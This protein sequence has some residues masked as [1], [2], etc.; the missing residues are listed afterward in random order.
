[1][2]TVILLR[3]ALLKKVD[4]FLFD[5]P[6]FQCTVTVVYSLFIYSVTVFNN[7]DKIFS[8]G[9][10]ASSSSLPENDGLVGEDD[11]VKAGRF[12]DRMHPYYRK[13]ACY[14]KTR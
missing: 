11:R 7:I 1:M 2:N 12:G 10:H 14:N 13:R 4:S 8:S 3:K 9:H 6:A 5:I